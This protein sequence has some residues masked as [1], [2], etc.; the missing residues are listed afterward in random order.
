MYN[1]RPEDIV[2]TVTAT[3]VN[4]NP[5]SSNDLNAELHSDKWTHDGDT[6]TFTTANYANGIYTIKF[7]YVDLA[8]RTGT[9]T[10]D[11]FIVDHDSPSAPKISYSES[12]LD[13]VLG[14]ISFG[15]YNPTVDV[16]FTSYDSFKGV[17]YFTWSY[18][19]QTGASDVIVKPS[20]YKEAKVAAQQDSS[21]MSKY[22]ATITL[23]LHEAEQLRGSIA[24][25][26][27]DKYSN[28]SEKTTDSG[29]VIVVD[30]ISP[31]MTVEY[32]AE[33]NKVGTTLYYGNDKSGKAEITFKVTEANFFAEDV[34]VKVS[35]NGETAVAVSPSWT[36]VSA[37]EHIGRYTLSGDGHYIVSVEYKDRSN[38]EMASYT[39][40]MITID[41][42][43][44][45]INVV[46]QNN[47]RWVMRIPQKLKKR[48]PN[49]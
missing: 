45:V 49:P 48:L 18:V 36:D 12:L 23:P 35:R 38:N 46:Y 47:M 10:T 32:S 13:T 19:K 27:T 43:K 25:T 33:S 39:S 11:A 8:K 4:G 34:V 37:D 28:V 1:F 40:D 42:I 20:D 44:P 6:H 5:V 30:T 31:T 17:D 3:D 26:A 9:F 14:S 24:A 16:K 29:K 21:D 41:T 22:T 15:F 2:A 7:D